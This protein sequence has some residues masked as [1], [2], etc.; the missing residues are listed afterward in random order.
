MSRD[1][2]APRTDDG[3]I[4]EARAR[5][6]SLRL[7]SASSR[8]GRKRVPAELRQEAVAFAKA[9]SALGRRYKA[10]ATALGLTADTLMRWCSASRKSKF[11]RVT[12]DGANGAQSSRSARACAKR[13]G[14]YSRCRR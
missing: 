7:K 12:E 10:I 13:A 3:R 9:E 4:G 11:A 6:D 5:A 14:A 1:R 2:F 8:D